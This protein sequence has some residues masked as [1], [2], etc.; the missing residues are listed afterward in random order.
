MTHAFA[1]RFKPWQNTLAIVVVGTAMNELDIVAM[2]SA[3]YKLNN[4]VVSV[5]CY[6]AM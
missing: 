3:C 4:A 5:L 6:T 1:F 2:W